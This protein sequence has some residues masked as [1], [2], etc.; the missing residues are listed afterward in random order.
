M[1]ESFIFLEA[2]WNFFYLLK[3]F[4]DQWV[5]LLCETAPRLV[6]FKCCRAEATKSLNQNIKSRAFIPKGF[7]SIGIK[8]K[9]KSLILRI[10]TRRNSNSKLRKFQS[11]SLHKFASAKLVTTQ[12]LFAK[13]GIY[14]VSIVGRTMKWIYQQTSR[15]SNVKRSKLRSNLKLHRWLTET[16]IR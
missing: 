9:K 11:L 3:G 12:T 8:A 7:Q 6:C 15:Y 5:G 1:N 16:F 13:K 4:W 2:R 10:G 14:N